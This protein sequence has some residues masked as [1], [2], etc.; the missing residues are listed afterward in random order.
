MCFSSVYSYAA[1]F[2]L[3]GLNRLIVIFYTYEYFLNF[4]TDI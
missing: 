1:K 3:N 4:Y 2:F